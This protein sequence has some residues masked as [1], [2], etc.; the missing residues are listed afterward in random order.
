MQIDEQTIEIYKKDQVD[1]WAA[2]KVVNIP[3]VEILRGLVRHAQQELEYRQVP[4]IAAYR[5]GLSIAFG[6]LAI[7]QRGVTIKNSMLSWNEIAGIGVGESEVMI[8]RKGNPVSWQ[9]FPLWM[10]ADAS[11]LEELIDYIM[12]RSALQP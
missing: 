11:S 5:A 1:V 10:I 2:L 6:P 8:K 9:V 4:S 12:R 7:S 3:N